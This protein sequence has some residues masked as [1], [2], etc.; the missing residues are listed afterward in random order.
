[1]LFDRV[2]QD[3]TIVKAFKSRGYITSLSYGPYDNGHVLVGTSTGDFLAFNSMN[4][5]KICN[6]KV[7]QYPVTSITIEPT[8]SILLGVQDTQ[9]VI[10]LTFI[11]NKYKYV[12]I[13]LGQKKFATLKQVISTQNERA[14]SRGREEKLVKNN[15]QREHVGCLPGF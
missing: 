13:E 2:K 3:M 10:A 8:Q 12:Y 7:A 6:V 9:E 4:L 15:Q 1:M 14:K 11:E 5:R